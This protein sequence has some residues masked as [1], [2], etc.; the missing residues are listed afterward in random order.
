MMAFFSAGM[1][2]AGVYFTTPVL[3][4]EAQLMMASIGVLLLGS[5]PP[6]WMTGSPFSRSNAAVSFSL[7]VGDSQMDLASWLKLMASVLW[8]E[9]SPR[10]L[11]GSN[12]IQDL[13][14]L[15]R[16]VMCVT[17]R[18]LAPNAGEVVGGERQHG[19]ER[20]PGAAVD[21]GFMF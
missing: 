16:Y 20:L 2:S 1:P 13:Q 19:G 4:S 7:S 5:P 21:D 18:S 9:C 10:S 3:S 8:V 14:M 11:T 6:R 15:F 17:F 12:S